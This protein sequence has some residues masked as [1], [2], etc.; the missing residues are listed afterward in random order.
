MSWVYDKDSAGHTD[1]TANSL[2][3]TIAK[4]LIA[5]EIVAEAAQDV[6]WPSGSRED[7]MVDCLLKLIV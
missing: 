7:L 4:K 5:D 6:R 3:L 1:S 2:I